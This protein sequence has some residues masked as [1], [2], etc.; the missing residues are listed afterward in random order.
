MRETCQERSS[1]SQEIYLFGHNMVLDINLH[2]YYPLDR[3]F[4][5]PPYHP[6]SI[7]FYTAA[8]H[9]VP[10]FDLPN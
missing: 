3:V 5:T 1:N 2:V 9:T 8:S 4:E 6:F 7:C 10:A